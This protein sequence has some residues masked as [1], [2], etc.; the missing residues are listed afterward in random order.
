[1]KGVVEKGV[2]E[3]VS[4]SVT[5]TEDR[6]TEV[7]TRVEGVAPSV[8][9]V[10]R[11]H[12][13][14]T[15]QSFTDRF[16]GLGVA[17]E[18]FVPRN[19]P[20]N[21]ASLAG[22]AS[23]AASKA[24]RNVIQE[25]SEEDSE[26]ENTEEN[27]EENPPSQPPKTMT[28]FSQKIRVWRTDCRAHQYLKEAKESPNQTIARYALTLA[29][30][31]FTVE[32]IPGVKMPG[33][34]ITHRVQC[35]RQIQYNTIQG[36][37]MIAD[38]L[39]RMVLLPAERDSMTLPEIC[40]GETMGKRIFAEKAGRKLIQNP[41]LFYTPQSQIKL[42]EEIEKE[43]DFEDG[44]RRERV[45]CHCVVPITEHE[46]AAEGLKDVFE[47]STS[48]IKDIP[49]FQVSEETLQSE[50]SAENSADK[51]AENSVENPAEESTQSKKTPEVRNL[52]HL[53]PT[54][55]RGEEIKSEAMRHVRAFILYNKLPELPELRG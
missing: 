9:P 11:S 18:D 31:N 26:E 4:Q 6:L 53:E 27:P 34:A 10:R 19:L 44:V 35:G 3:P 13:E 5:T 46:R 41:L 28:T 42:C 14:S 47:I 40:F 23:K 15:E 30:Y 36:V 21:I 25:D 48:R 43:E 20:Q 55:T 17:L 52:S 50:K 2:V 39:S 38:P 54:L 8:P 51:S 37:K 49:L 33:P 29:D 7:A 16:R 45:I 1:M 32:W 24:A 22:V 12:H